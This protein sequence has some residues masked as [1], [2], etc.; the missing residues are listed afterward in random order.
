V[1]NQITCSI[2]ARI[3]LLGNPSDGYFGAC[4]S[5]PVYNWQAT[6]VI[7]P[8]DSTDEPHKLPDNS[9]L[10]RIMGPTITV[11]EKRFGLTAS[12]FKAE[13]ETTIPRQVGLSG[14]S[15]IET[16]F[17]L[18]LMAYHDIPLDSLTPRE[19]AE[20]ILKI[21]SEELGMVAGLQDRLPQA[22]G[23]MLYMDFDEK[24]MEARGFG[25]YTELDSAHLPRLWVAHATSGKDSGETHS[26]I[27]KRWQEKDP[28]MVDIIHHLAECAN[29]GRDAI[30]SNDEIALASLI[31]T[32][33]DLRR[34]L[35]GDVAL[36]E[37]LDAV[38]LA[39]SMGSC[40]KQCGSGGSIVGIITD[41]DFLENAAVAFSEMGWTFHADVEVVM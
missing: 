27:A 5:L 36:G 25:D 40:A 11:F 24:L 38:K 7:S 32:N 35:F 22:Y 6:V 1:A 23:C 34:E 29:N 14:S 18:T 13:I 26:N 28:E 21:E 37:T 16:A 12:P 15:A 31:D 19:L 2:P 4:I 30:L 10:R 20:L 9:G 3:G 33:F 39:R 41:N 17:M 8:N